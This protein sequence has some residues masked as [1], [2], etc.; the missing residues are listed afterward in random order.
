M[1]RESYRQ[2][3]S[4]LLDGGYTDDRS[5]LTAMHQVKTRCPSLIASINR[6]VGEDIAA[7]KLN[8]AGAAMIDVVGDAE[9]LNP[10]GRW[11][12]SR[13]FLDQD[14]ED[15]M[16]IVYLPCLDPEHPFVIS[17]TEAYSRYGVPNMEVQATDSVLE[18]S[19]KVS[20]TTRSV[21]TSRPNISKISPDFLQYVRTCLLHS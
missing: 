8:G 20:F 18:W 6:K 7:E 21:G 13:K 1:L 12:I 2:T 16:S 5:L 3:V 9:H 4:M 10:H 15:W 14:P 11:K 19:Q 17:L